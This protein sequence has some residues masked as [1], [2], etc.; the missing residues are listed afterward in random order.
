MFKNLALKYFDKTPI[1]R[2]VTR[3]TNDVESLNE[4]FSSGI[5]MVFSDVF[6]II[7]IFIFMF[8]LSWDLSLVTLS[9]LPALFYGTFLFRRK[10]RDAYR[11]VRKYL[12]ALNSYMQE[13]ITGMSIVQLFTKEKEEINKFSGINEKH[14][15]ANIA[16]I[17]YYAVFSPLL[18]FS[19]LLQLLL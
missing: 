5:V 3:V 10:V 11:D 2:I 19:V 7:W 8:F 18:K 13:H 12:A 6:I 15:Q 1:G 16:S 14:K 9:V 17:F 4:M